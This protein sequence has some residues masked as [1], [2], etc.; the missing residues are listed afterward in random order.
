MF[1]VCC[2][3]RARLGPERIR[4]LPASEL[5]AVLFVCFLLR[6]SSCPDLVDGSRSELSLGEAGPKWLGQRSS[7][8]TVLSTVGT[9]VHGG[10]EASASDGQALKWRAPDVRMTIGQENASGQD[11]KRAGSPGDIVNH[12]DG[13]RHNAS[14]S[15]K[16]QG[17]YKL[18]AMKGNGFMADWKGQ[19][20]G[21]H[22]F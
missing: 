13:C 15:S 8:S 6:S 19:S 1:C 4:A 22:R 2:P 3:F 20:S 10:S 18:L 16:R 21:C 5:P 9:T 7:A 12:S 17:S 14:S 11:T